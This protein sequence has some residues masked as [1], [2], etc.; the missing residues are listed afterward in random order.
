MQSQSVFTGAPQELIL[1][2]HA[3]TD[4]AGTLCGQSNPPL[5]AMGRKQ[6]KLLAHL[7]QGC[8]F[9]RLY[10][11][12]LLRAVETAQPLQLL[13]DADLVVRKELRE[14]DFGEWEGKRWSQIHRDGAGITSLESSPDLCP[15]GGET[16]GCFRDRV[17]RELNEIAADC[18]RAPTIVVT[19]LGVIR[20]ALK[21]LG[22]ANEALALPHRIDY[23]SVHR[24]L[25]KT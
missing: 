23:C 22:P 1:I 7:L 4:M 12:D 18:N 3:A 9:R 11:S 25:I 6:A 14:I 10:T 17:L 15:P 19:H 16:F 21:E 20:L 2:R 13:C 8:K 24:L 5:N